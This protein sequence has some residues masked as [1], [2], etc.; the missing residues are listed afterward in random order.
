MAE[1][2]KIKSRT[3]TPNPVDVF[4]T[5]RE[6]RK[7]QEQ[8]KKLREDKL[9]FENLGIT[10][11]DKTEDLSKRKE[12]EREIDWS[13]KKL[14]MDSRGLDGLEGGSKQKKGVDFEETL[15]M[16]EL[17]RNHKDMKQEIIRLSNKQAMLE[18]EDIANKRKQEREKE[19]QDFKIDNLTLERT[20]RRG[21][22]RVSTTDLEEMRNLR[23][24]LETLE[25]GA[26]RKLIPKRLLN[27]VRSHTDAIFGDLVL[28]E[29]T[30]SPSHNTPSKTMK[31]FNQN[32]NLKYN[33]GDNWD[34]FLRILVSY[35]RNYPYMTKKEFSWALIKSLGP[36]AVYEVPIEVFNWEY[37]ALTYYLCSI[38]GQPSS[39]MAKLNDFS[40]YQGT[41]AYD[42]KDMVKILSDL[43]KLAE[44]DADT[45][46]SKFLHIAPSRV[47]E[48]FTPLVEEILR[49]NNGTF[50]Q[51]FIPLMFIIHRL[52][53]HPIYNVKL[54]KQDSKKVAFGIRNVPITV[55][56][57]GGGKDDKNK[58]KPCRICGSQVGHIPWWACPEKLY[59]QLCSGSNHRA[60]DCSVY[61]REQTLPNE[62]SI[63][64]KIMGKKL[65]HS[66][67]VCKNRTIKN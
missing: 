3:T 37:K 34:T 13:N 53:Q 24:R 11:G 9:E 66:E 48:H 19:E 27:D 32:Y 55:S 41:D 7:L 57:G 51:D 6:Y 45:F 46:M 42:I 64:K 56:A 15:S 18:V 35:A 49:D 12:G 16:G 8:E 25:N 26:Q 44:V 29:D 36:K 30:V 1:S 5:A 17:L 39:R 4:N 23:E 63:C 47:S 59:C 2:D 60:P 21:G 62:C 20:E 10:G 50:P 40:S 61:Y 52:D 54:G 65:F 58:P 33:K 67:K 43:A 22:D 31:D 14:M 38:F 28:C